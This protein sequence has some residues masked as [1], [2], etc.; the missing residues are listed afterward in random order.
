M[1][2]TTNHFD[3]IKNRID[4]ELEATNLSK[5]KKLDEAAKLSL[6]NSQYAAALEVFHEKKTQSNRLAN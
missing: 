4:S 2:L 5:K 6:L 3:E 1:K